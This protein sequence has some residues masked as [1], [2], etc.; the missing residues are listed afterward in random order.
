LPV[1]INQT[2][3]ERCW[4]LKKAG[5]KSRERPT[6]VAHSKPSQATRVA[7]AS[8]AAPIEATAPAESESA[9]KAWFTATFGAL[10]GSD[11]T[12]TETREPAAN[13]PPRKRRSNAAE[14]SE[15]SKAKPPQQSSA[16]ASAAEAVAEKSVAAPSDQEKALYEEFLEWR[17]KHLLFQ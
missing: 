10:T 17:V 9:I 14:R 1:H 4:Y 6:G 8:R 5:A 15:S 12:S 7:T 2:T 3:K 11:T 16:S 13:E